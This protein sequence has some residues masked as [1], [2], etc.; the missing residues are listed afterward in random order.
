MKNI[1]I[2]ALVASA[3]AI[4]M[5]QALSQKYWDENGVWRNLKFPEDE[6]KY[7][8]RYKAI[9]RSEVKHFEDH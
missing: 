4:T 1:V 5:R 3:S 8:E 9:V 6:T 7:E 2:A